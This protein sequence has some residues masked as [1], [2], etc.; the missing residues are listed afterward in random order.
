M[1]AAGAALVAAGCGGAN[2]EPVP[3]KPS[4][5]ALS[6]AVDRV[7]EQR[8]FAFDAEWTRVRADKPDE[9][10]RYA[11][12]EGAVDAVARSGRVTIQLR[13]GIPGPPTAVEQPIELR[14]TPQTLQG[15]VAGHCNTLSRARSRE[16]AGLVARLADE[17]DALVGLLAHA[18]H[19]RQT[20]REKVGGAATV[21]YDFAVDAR[22]AGR[23]GIPAE[24]SEAFER[25]IYGREL[26]MHAWIDQDGLPRRI[27]YEIHM[28]PVRAA[29]RQILPKRTVTATY[30]LHDF[31]E[32][33]DVGTKPCP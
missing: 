12:A 1:L 8:T 19:P 26:L 11:E 31:G 24:L 33:A 28:R 16:D 25:S 29:G 5:A 22:S 2:D 9:T 20:G 7:R 6:D 27:A 10:E 21:R 32:E 30:D 15:R 3:A 23:R 4:A 13:I 18:R 14:W 17:H